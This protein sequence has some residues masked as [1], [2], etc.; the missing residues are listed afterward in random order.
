MRWALRVLRRAAL[1]LGAVLGFTAVLVAAAWGV[2][3]TEWGRDSLANVLAE[4]LS[5][6]D[7]V[8]T[9]QSLEGPLPQHI[10]LRG[11][12]ISD[13]KGPRIT[14]DSLSID[15]S[16]WGLLQGRIHVRAA[17]ASRIEIL[18]PGEGET[19]WAAL[20]S[21]IAEFPYAVIVDRLSVQKLSLGKAILGQPATIRVDATL[22]GRAGSVLRTELTVDRIDGQGGGGHVRAVLDIA[23]ERLDLEVAINEPAGGVL[24]GLLD[25]PDHP[26]LAVTLSG[27]GVL[28]DW[29]GK[30]SA[31]AEGQGSVTAEIGLTGPDPFRVSAR[32]ALE[33][34]SLEDETLRAWLAPGL[35]FD[36]AADWT[37]G[38]RVLGF[39]HIRLH[40]T[41]FEGAFAGSI[42][43]GEMTVAGEL[44]LATHDPSALNRLLE[45]LS[46]THGSLKAK[47]EGPLTQPVAQTQWTLEGPDI[48]GIRADRLLA[49]VTVTADRPLAHAGLK[50]GLDGTLDIEGLDTGDQVAHA[51]L[52]SS[53]KLDLRGDYDLDGGLLAASDLTVTG[54]AVTARG[55]GALAIDGPSADLAATINLPDLTRLPLESLPITEGGV[56]ITVYGRAGPTG[57]DGVV[58]AE[59]RDLSHEDAEIGR[60]L[61][62]ALAVSADIAGDAASGWRVANLA[63][64]ART[65]QVSGDAQLAPDFARLDSRFRVAAPDLDPFSELATIPL[66][67]TLD[68]RGTA[69]GNLAD[70]ALEGTLTLSDLTVSEF[71]LSKVT[72]DVSIERIATQPQGR[73]ALT[74]VGPEGEIRGS[75]RFVVADGEQVRLEG[76][77]LRALATTVRGDLTV[78]LSGGAA[79]GRLSVTAADLAA[80]AG[81][82]GLTASGQAEG[83]VSLREENGGQAID[84]DL[85]GSNLRVEVSPDSQVIVGGLRL[86][87]ELDDLASVPRFTGRVVA[88]KLAQGNLSFDRLTGEVSGTL[89]DA[90]FRLEGQGEIPGDFAAE[91][92]LKREGESLDVT[93]ASF[94]GQLA[95]QEVRLEQPVRLVYGPQRVAVEALDIAWAGGRIQ[96]NVRWSP[97]D[98]EA[99]LRATRLPLALARLFM[100]E[101]PF[102]GR[103]DAR[104]D[105]AGPA[106]EPMGD[107]LFEVNDLTLA[108]PVQPEA[109][110]PPLGVRLAG[111]LEKGRLSLQG[112]MSGL[113]DTKLDVSGDLPVT[114]SFHPLD[115]DLAT[116]QPIQ[117]R[118]GFSGDLQSLWTLFPIDPHR[119]RGRGE[120]DIEVAGT[121]AQPVV[122]GAVGLRDGTYE[123]LETGT[124]LSEIAVSGDLEGRQ[125]ILREATAT[126]GGKGRLTGSGTIDLAPEQDFPVRIDLALA[127]ATLIARDDVTAAASGDLGLAGTLA[128]PLLRGT[129]TAQPVEVRVVGGVPASVVTL[130]VTEVNAPAREPRKTKPADEVVV[131]LDLALSIPRRLFVRGRGLDS[132][133]AGDFEIGGTSAAPVVTGVLRPVRGDFSLA[134]KTFKFQEGSITF[135]GGAELVPILDLAAEHAT[136]DLT[137]VIRVRGPAT[138]PE[139]TLASRPELPREEILSRV[140]FNRGTGQISALEAAQLAAAAAEL[141]G[142]GGSGPGILDRA[143]AVLGVDVLRFGAAEGSAA[144]NMTAGRYVADGVYVGVTQGTTADS[145]AA[146]V[147]VEVTPNIAVE[148]DVGSDA[149]GRVG[150]RWRY[151]Y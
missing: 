72:G 134:G 12:A 68:I 45:P 56:E 120:A 91:G 126:D 59:L 114:L 36:L 33:G 49:A 25:I 31:R 9:I 143:R 39:E 2:L 102:D 75:T 117:G 90:G 70:P 135:E 30:L 77:D 76:L 150:V 105:L 4:N 85:S 113:A 118:A 100:P 74:A 151:D 73:L 34:L 63:V 38:P 115:F 13:A 10:G 44:S 41:L 67:G 60:L 23:S 125:L 101:A 119:L 50:I 20:A 16:P 62:P 8:V 17:E 140:L 108:D 123:N 11:V 43:L 148:S 121:L 116:T 65:L 26:P 46:V 124:Q 82:A 87:G 88:T 127:D 6:P 3:A 128:S 40:N 138:A 98:M 7:A 55:S 86:A 24:A 1:G 131:G 21:D 18:R 81:R 111:R 136:S 99:T 19:D 109:A 103:L 14:V 42:A 35:E 66:K 48:E 106:Q 137:A 84:A 28:S 93:L 141:G 57:L 92:Q 22:A 110:P 132:E 32:G 97:A 83:T 96:T 145:T 15:W 130:D 54:R 104:I 80:L 139:I 53:V 51:L 47:I 112:A 142:V 69:K 37:A 5:A 52:G 89:A 71:R 61:G 149:R 107:L 79:A 144:P 64:D 78:P 27:E 129:I 133:W 94:Q 95:G 122:Q 147:G 146:T 29:R 58:T